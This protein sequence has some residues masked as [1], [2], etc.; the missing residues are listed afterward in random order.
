MPLYKVLVDDNFH[1]QDVN[2]RREHGVY[3]TMEEALEVCRRV[4][5]ESLEKEFKPGMSPEA[6]YDRYVS[7]GD[8]PFI[9]ACGGE[10]KKDIFSAWEYAKRRCGIICRGH[11]GN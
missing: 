6:L 8:D 7:F 2:E 3:D 9:V 5:D 4:V 10:D 1:Y 11:C